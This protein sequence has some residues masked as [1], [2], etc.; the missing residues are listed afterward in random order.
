MKIILLFLSTLMYLSATPHRVK[1][2]VSG[3]A[4]GEG[5]YTNA[6]ASD[7]RTK[8]DTYRIYTGM[9]M[10]KRLGSLN[11]VLHMP[12]TYFEKLCG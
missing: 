12:S 3:T 5:S 1:V 10:Q 11:A 8:K 7:L 9:Y 6:S 4:A 2:S